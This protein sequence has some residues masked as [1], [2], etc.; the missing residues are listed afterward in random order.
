MPENVYNGLSCLWLVL[1][2]VLVQV[3]CPCTVSS[4]GTG[5]DKYG[6]HQL[7]RLWEPKMAVM[8]LWKLHKQ[9]A[10][11]KYSPMLYLDSVKEYFLRFWYFWTDFLI[12]I[13]CYSLILLFLK[14]G[15]SLTELSFYFIFWRKPSYLYYIIFYESPPSSSRLEMFFLTKCSNY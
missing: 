13:M 10:K 15:H 2:G 3:A 14:E 11:E 1:H 9:K 6:L 4:L 8:A 7:R 12:S 5:I